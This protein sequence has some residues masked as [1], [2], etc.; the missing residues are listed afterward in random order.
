MTRVAET[1]PAG[2]AAACGSDGPT[3]R[4]R[5]L[6]LYEDAFGDEGAFGGEDTYGEVSEIIWED[7]PWISARERP[8]LPDISSKDEGNSC[9][10]LESALIWGVVDFIRR[11]MGSVDPTTQAGIDEAL[12][13]SRFGLETYWPQKGAD[14]PRE[15]TP[16]QAAV[17]A[18][19]EERLGIDPDGAGAGKDP[20]F[21]EENLATF[22][23]QLKSLEAEANRGAGEIKQRYSEF[24]A[25]FI[26]ATMELLEPRDISHMF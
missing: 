10:A 3:H 11:D 15:S 5:L 23:A 14:E 12:M 8:G 7:V 9:S 1:A 22:R 18:M 13:D 25:W 2:D 16:L 17:L 4:V 21:L 6:S 20:A 26:P 19:I 24:Q